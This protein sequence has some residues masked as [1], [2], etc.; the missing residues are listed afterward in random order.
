VN[1]AFGSGVP[2]LA[3]GVNSCSDGKSHESALGNQPMRGVKF[4]ERTKEFI[5]TIS[6]AICFF[7]AWIWRATVAGSPLLDAIVISAATIATLLAVKQ[8]LP[9]QNIMGLIVTIAAFWWATLLIAKVFGIL[10]YPP[11]FNFHFFREYEFGLFWIVGIINARGIAKSVLHRWRKSAN[12]GLW[13]LALG[14][15]LLVVE[16][17]DA[18]QHL[19]YFA[20]K[21]LFVAI[22][23]TATTPW[24]ID[25]KRIEQKPDYQSLLITILLLLW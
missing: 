4:C 1:W 3:F 22:V 21:F 9:L 15:F 20:E 10:F 8:R 5:P 19:V 2:R 18:R 14:S 16:D 23:F 17:P 13:L 6:F 24:F 11:L 25:K 12:Y 7:A